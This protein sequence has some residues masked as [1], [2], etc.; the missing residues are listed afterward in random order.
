MASRGGVYARESAWQRPGFWRLDCWLFA[1]GYWMLGASMR[2]QIFR[3]LSGVF[4]M[5]CRGA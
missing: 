1:A 2:F 3:K 5:T 4:S